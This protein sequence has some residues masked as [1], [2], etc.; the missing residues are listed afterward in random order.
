MCGI[1]AIINKNDQSVPDAFI[2]KMTSLVTHRG[3]DDEGFYHH[4]N[5][6]FGH[7]RL[8]IIDL[9]PLG[10]QPMFYQG[11][12]IVYNGEIYNY[13][14]IREELI[15]LGYA[16][17]TQSDTEVILAAYDCWGVNC[18]NHFN[19]MWSFVLYDIKK[20]SLFCSRDRFG[21]KPLCYT[22]A[23]GYFM[24]G[25]EI[26]QF[27]AN[28]SFSPRLNYN[29]AANF[30]LSGS[31][32]YSEHT[33]F[34]SV[35]EIPGGHYGIYD[36]HQHNFSVYKWYHLDKVTQLNSIS[37]KEAAEKMKELF[38]DSIRLRLRS[39]V[40]VGTC[41]SGGIDSSSIAMGVQ[42][43]LPPGHL[44][45]TVSSC[46]PGTIYD[47]QEYIDAVITKT[48]FEAIKIYPDL[49]EV[50]KEGMMEKL[51]WHQDQP[52]PSMSHFS[53]YKVFEA[54]R[55][56]KLIVMLDGQGSDEYLAGYGEFY[57]H[58]QYQLFKQGN[59]IKWINEVRMRAKL[60]KQ[61]L[62]WVLGNAIRFNRN[63]EKNK[64]NPFQ[65][66]E[67]LFSE[68]FS[69]TDIKNTPVSHSVF[70][71]SKDQILRS[72]IPYQLHSEDRNSM[73]HSI[74]SRVPFL[75][76][77]LVEF[78]LSL[79]DEM[80]IK[81]GVTKHI[82]RKALQKELPESIYARHS[83]LGFPAP[84]NEWMKTQHPWFINQLQ[85]ASKE[86]PA[87]FGKT[88]A[89][90]FSQDIHSNKFLS[91]YFRTLSLYTWMKVFNVNSNS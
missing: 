7:R 70:E 25:S 87:V 51:I 32:N 91:P 13:I 40:K 14:E 68:K 56:N 45:Y 12:V 22:D 75:D 69:Q 4:K 39:D 31:L 47:E 89:E 64:E 9:S 53:E 83:K 29:T 16:F 2:R 28:S 78:G 49:Q 58:F 42:T 17:A 30:L 67:F 18:L 62:R 3:P 43:Q 34:E 10:H 21:V 23:G 52:L 63:N 36:L 65:E 5:L 8:S 72:S 27:T 11:N 81:N 79:P 33:F 90:R 86:Y 44:F 1:V 46:Y 6:A 15:K 85:N 71:L 59:Y 88:I 37:E 35:K 50:Q 74:E 76:Y 60:R 41:L 80:K 26:K 77:R 19:G 84:E 48:G 73:M 61:S 38:F 24:I 66:N 54:A 82:L 20:N 55:L 57:T